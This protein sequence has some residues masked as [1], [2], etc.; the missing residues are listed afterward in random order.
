NSVLRSRLEKLVELARSAVDEGRRSV[1]VLRAPVQP[2]ES[3]EVALAKTPQDLGQTGPP[4]Q[5]LVRGDTAWE[6]PAKAW[7]EVYMIGREA[8]LNAYKHSGGDE[9][10]VSI[11]YEP[12]GL[13]LCVRD[14][15]RGIGPGELASG[16]PG[17]W[18]LQG[19]RERARRLGAKLQ[20]QTA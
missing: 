5:V 8:I 18:G 15:G 9:I 20:F 19:M 13:R 12:T 3:L 2:S 7:H 17:H 16:L 14:N 10:H 6:L 1:S 4:L 11:E